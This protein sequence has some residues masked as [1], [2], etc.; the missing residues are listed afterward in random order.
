MCLVAGVRNRPSSAGEMNVVQRL[1]V[2][3]F[4]T[5]PAGEQMQSLDRLREAVSENSL[6]Y[7]GFYSP[8]NSALSIERLFELWI[9]IRGNKGTHFVPSFRRH[10]LQRRWRCFLSLEGAGRVRS[11]MKITIVIPPVL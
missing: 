8:K 9:R 4:K 2:Q 11:S 10:M 3:T 6:E 7:S 1:L 5:F